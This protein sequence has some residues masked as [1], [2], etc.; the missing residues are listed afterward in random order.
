[1]FLVVLDQPDLANAA[2]FRRESNLQRE[3]DIC[4]SKYESRAYLTRWDRVLDHFEDGRVE[5]PVTLPVSHG[6]TRLEML[7][8]VI[9]TNGPTIENHTTETTPQKSDH[10]KHITYP[11]IDHTFSPSFLL[12]YRAPHQRKPIK[13]HSPSQQKQ[14]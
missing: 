11:H 8:E 5:T 13:C 3:S 6:I 10:K 1:M 14:P 4:K 9:D 7:G 12:L 2:V